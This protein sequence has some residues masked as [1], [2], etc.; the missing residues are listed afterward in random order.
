[1]LRYLA[2]VAAS[3]LGLPSPSGAPAAPDDAS[4]CRFSKANPIAESSTWFDQFK[5][6]Q[7]GGRHLN[8]VGS[9]AF[10]AG[11]LS[12]GVCVLGVAHDRVQVGA[13]G[14]FGGDAT[15]IIPFTAL[16]YVGDDAR[17]EN[18]NIFL[19]ALFHR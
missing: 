6:Y 15:L 11:N 18:V 8:V 13:C 16:A 19:Q 17:G 2:L 7:S 9:G 1:M 14:S 5:C 3:A 10:E 4:D 12:G